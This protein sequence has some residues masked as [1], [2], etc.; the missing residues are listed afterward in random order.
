MAK[1]EVKADMA[2]DKAEK[3]GMNKYDRKRT[4]EAE[5]EE[6]SQEKVSETLNLDEDS[7][8]ARKKQV[9]LK[10]RNLNTHEKTEQMEAVNLDEDGNDVRKRQVSLKFRKWN[11]HEKTERMLKLETLRAERLVVLQ[12]R[13][14]KLPVIKNLNFSTSVQQLV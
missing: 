4:D 12:K 1:K 2:M 8:E 11:T 13:A 9:S 7:N 14:K 10:F 6:E 3:N 5:E